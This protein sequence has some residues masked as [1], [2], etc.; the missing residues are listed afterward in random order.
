MRDTRRMDP[1][2]IDQ[3]V[4]EAERATAL[5]CLDHLIALCDAAEAERA[6]T[7]VAFHVTG[8]GEHCRAYGHRLTFGCCLRAYERGDKSIMDD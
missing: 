1:L 5:G 2:E 7:E 6:L 3:L 8:S 4:D